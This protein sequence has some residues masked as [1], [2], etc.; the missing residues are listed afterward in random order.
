MRVNVKILRMNESSGRLLCTK[1][2]TANGFA[3]WIRT[4][5]Q[6][7]Q[8]DFDDTHGNRGRV[9]A[10]KAFAAH[11]D[12][13]FREN[14]QLGRE[15]PYFTEDSDN[16]HYRQRGS[17]LL[18]ILGD[19]LCSDGNEVVEAIIE[20]LPDVSWHDISQGAEAFYD[21]TAPYESIATVEAEERANQ[22]EYWYER[23]FVYQ[24]EEFCEKVQYER[25]FFK[26]KELLDKLFGKPTEYE[27]G[28][29]N[30]VY[31][32][33][34]DQRI[35]R[36]R[37]LDDEFT[38][39]VLSRNSETHLGAPPRDRAPAGR[40]N[41]E[42]IPALYGAFSKDTAVAEIRPGIGDEIAIG[43]FVLQRDLRVFDFTAF[44]RA[45]REKW[46]EVYSHTRYDFIKQMEDQI[47]RRVLPF[48]K[49]RQYIPTQI[50]AEYLK[51]YFGCEAVIYSSSMI[52]DR[53]AENRNIVFLPRAE[54]F[55]G[56]DAAVLKYERYTV[57]EVMDVTYQLGGHP[58]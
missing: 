35:F 34:A 8:C 49:Q 4:N 44:S 21:D 13:F 15:E 27:G 22:Q 10:V 57:T 37:I 42:F 12:E 7:G 16:V 29:I 54:G 39:D 25:R 46:N 47:G 9:V 30:P 53:S 26:I 28:P 32:L 3:K 56:G 43:E 41:V 6:R 2:I 31:A 5:G 24:W 23:R 52:R 18:E 45:P 51:E 20:N 55:V 36:A 58:F 38:G 17:S 40:M 33:K 50:V 14:Y 1:C 48:E 19:E 11:V